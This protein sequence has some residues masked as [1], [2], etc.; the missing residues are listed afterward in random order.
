MLYD[1]P[2]AGRLYFGP[3]CAWP[4]PVVTL[5]KNLLLS[6][7]II[8]HQKLDLTVQKEPLIQNFIFVI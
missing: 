6:E 2:P 3:A 5:H 4:A 7:R 8:K 1:R